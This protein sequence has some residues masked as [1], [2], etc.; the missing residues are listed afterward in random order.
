[1]S[2]YKTDFILFMSKSFLHCT[3]HIAINQTRIQEVKGTKFLG[4]IIDNKLKWIL[5]TSLYPYVS[6]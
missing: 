2:N 1:M 5:R 4:V 6:Y 3:D